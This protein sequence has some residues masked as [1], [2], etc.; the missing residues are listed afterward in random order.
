MN[1][2]PS[3]RLRPATRRDMDAVAEILRST[4]DW[5]AR[6]VDDDDMDQH[7]VDDAW[8]DENFRLREFFVLVEHGEVLGTVSLQEAG[9]HLYLGYVYLHAEATGR[10]LGRALLD[11]AVA[12]GERRGK[13]GLV[14]IAHPEAHWAMKAY[15]RYGFDVIASSRDDVL[16]WNDGFMTPYYEEGFV[17]HRYALPEAASDAA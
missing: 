3:W 9:D 5:Y 2:T 16:A 11:H 14:L 12:E 15:A 10:G 1:T 17:L 4:A 8:A 7:D 13:R 6:F